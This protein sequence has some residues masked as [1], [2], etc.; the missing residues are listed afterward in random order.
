MVS[1]SFPPTCWTCRRCPSSGSQH[2]VI[3]FVPGCS[4]YGR[5]RAR[6]WTKRTLPSARNT[7]S[8]RA[9]KG[10]QRGAV[11]WQL[12]EI[13][14]GVSCSEMSKVWRPWSAFWKWRALA[15]F[16]GFSSKGSKAKVDN[17][18]INSLSWKL[19]ATVVLS[20]QTLGDSGD[21][22]DPAVVCWFGA[23]NGLDLWTTIDYFTRYSLPV[24]FA[25][26]KSI[27]PIGRSQLFP[28]LQV[29]M[30]A[31]GD[32]FLYFQ[33]LKPRVVFWS[34]QDW[35]HWWGWG[36]WWDGSASLL[37]L[38]YCTCLRKSCF[39]CCMKSEKE[40]KR[41]LQSISS[42]GWLKGNSTQEKQAVLTGKNKQLSCKFDLQLLRKIALRGSLSRFLRV[43]PSPKMGLSE[44]VG[45][46]PN[47]SH[48]S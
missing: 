41:L 12:P 6:K 1:R 27:G 25:I 2:C 5:D 23:S 29:P 35:H 37:W 17:L 36:F 4:L 20:H 11:A 34:S 13:W 3:F 44:N 19:R 15:S 32:H 39:T 48:F 46:I 21:S 22:G 28:T 30:F 40:G 26:M 8:V 7:W 43:H 47:Y 33:G 9:Q 16:L 14:D 24:C 45:Y 42:L 31:H 10:P 18:I 38:L